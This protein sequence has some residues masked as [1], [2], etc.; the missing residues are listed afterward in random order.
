VDEQ[1]YAVRR[2]RVAQS[3]ARAHYFAHIDL[4]GLARYGGDGGMDSNVVIDAE[5]ALAV[6]GQG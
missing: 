2:S 5:K 4:R 6:V 1:D 3:G